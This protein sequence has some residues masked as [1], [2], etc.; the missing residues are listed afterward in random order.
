MI[1]PTQSIKKIALV[2]SPNV[3]K[4]VIFN[5][6]T[7]NY[8]IVSNYPGTTVD[9][10]RGFLTLGERRYEVTD[11]P[12]MY[13]LSSLTGEELISRHLLEAEKPDVVLCVG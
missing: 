8:A 13:S 11:T 10:L 6:L 2:G 4:S 5:C 7:G 12:G 3:G 9:I 1:K